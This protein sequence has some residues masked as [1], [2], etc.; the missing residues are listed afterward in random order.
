[1][2]FTTASYNQKISYNLRKEVERSILCSWTGSFN[3]FKIIVLLKLIIDL[4]Q[5]QSK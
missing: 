1:M 5:A 2:S 4:S 3:T